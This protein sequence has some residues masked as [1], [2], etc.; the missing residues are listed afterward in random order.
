MTAADTAPARAFPIRWLVTMVTFL[1]AGVSFLDRN[2]I[3]IAAASVQKD[4]GL[5]DQKMGVVFSAFVAG[6]ALCQPLAG[7]VADRFGPHKVVTVGI[8]W[9]SLFTAAVAFVPAGQSWSL[10]A[11]LGVLAALGVG[12]SVIFPSSNRLV[13]AWIPI[14]ERGRANGLI[15]AGVGVGASV[16][17]PLITYLILNHSWRWSFVASAMIGVVAGLLWLG[18]VRSK[19]QDHPWISR[20]EL[21]KIET[22]IAGQ[23]MDHGGATLSHA[24]RNPSIWLLSLSYFCYGYVAY[25]FFT[26]FFKYL[27]VV[28]GLNLKSSAVYATLPFLA[29]AIGST[30]GGVISDRLTRRFGPRVG[31]SFFGSFALLLAGGFIWGVT[32]AHGA[33]VT[34]IIL[35]GGAG[36]LYLSQ[37]VYWSVSADLGGRS[38]GSVSGVMNMSNQIGGVVTASLT[39]YLA[40]AFGW[41]ASF[42]FAAVLCAVSAGCWLAI[43]PRPRAA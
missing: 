8:L 33:E 16:A 38:A 24:L 9:W 43:N 11:L 15:F 36:A 7:R 23:G 22:G 10:L 14:P 26:W 19:P 41:N 29:M 18:L 25:I 6:Y 28:R 3:S 27:S 30:L 21:D 2:N 31:R 42:L 1:V 12:E 40:H 13:A 35:A 37:S 39:P 32:S 20:A 4:F 5:S 34:A 17:P